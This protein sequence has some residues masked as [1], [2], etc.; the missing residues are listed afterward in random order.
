MLSVQATALSMPL[1]QGD[2]VT[3]LQGVIWRA[4][5]IFLLICV[6]IVNIAVIILVVHLLIVILRRIL[7]LFTLLLLL[8]LVELVKILT[9]L[10]DNHIL[11]IILIFMVEKLLLLAVAELLEDS[12]TAFVFSQSA[13]GSP[14]RLLISTAWSRGAL[15]MFLVILIVVVICTSLVYKFFIV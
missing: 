7:L 9:V 14:L 15:F 11:V 13:L 3:L 1:Y 6:L 2:F 10:N 8:L 5:E 4:Q 12:L